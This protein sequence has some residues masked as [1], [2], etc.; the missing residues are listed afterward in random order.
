MPTKTGLTKSIIFGV[1]SMETAGRIDD[2]DKVS[3]I[4]AARFRC[5]TRLRELEQQFEG[6]GNPQGVHYRGGGNHRAGCGVA[7][8]WP[9]KRSST[10]SII[11]PGASS[12][13]AYDYPRHA[14]RP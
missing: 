5:Q 4:E 3:A 11:L 8:V 9:R 7:P 12:R 13:E 10:S 1:P 14:S 2:S 6:L